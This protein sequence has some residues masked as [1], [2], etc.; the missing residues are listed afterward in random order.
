MGRFQPPHE[1]TPAELVQSLH[2]F[3]QS[4]Q[5]PDALQAAEELLQLFPNSHIYLEQAAKFSARLQR[6]TDEAAY[7]ERYILTSPDPGQACPAL[8]HA[9]WQLKQIDKMIGAAKRCVALEPKNSDFLF[10][11]ALANERAGLI[12][13]ALLQYRAGKN[14][15]PRY[16]DFA[17]GF[18]RLL[19]R[20]DRAKEAWE[21]ISK[22]I[23]QTPGIADAELVAGLAAQR[24]DQ[25]DRARKIFVL[26][27][28][29][30]PDNQE[31]K[32]ALQTFLSQ[33]GEP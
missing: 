27:V 14:Q 32:E 16:T 33:H 26:A 1:R 21:E 25:I 15:F 19:L 13:E 31:L 3:E 2:K 18:A 5:W 28:K 30:H 20:S 17:I 4:E 23:D 22:I 12:Q 29:N 6:P 8:A 24:T 7:L 9:Y 10:D 11:L